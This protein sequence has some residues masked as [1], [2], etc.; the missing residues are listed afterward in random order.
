MRP[1]ME[2]EVANSRILVVDGDQ[3][4]RY[5]LSL[6]L[7]EKGLDVLTVTSV[8]KAV[9]I[10]D[11][12]PISVVILDQ[13]LPDTNGTNVCRMIRRNP[14]Y[15]AIPIV[16]LAED[17]SI[18]QR[19]RAY[20]NGAECFLVKPVSLRVLVASL[21]ALCRFRDRLLQ[22]RPVLQEE[23]RLQPAGL[24]DYDDRNSIPKLTVEHAIELGME[25]LRR[26]NTTAAIDWFRKAVE[27]DP[28]HVAARHYYK[29]AQAAFMRMINRKMGPLHNVPQH[30]MTDPNELA[31][32]EF[33][34][35]ESRIFYLIDGRSSFLEI[36]AHSPFTQEQ[37]LDLFRRLLA[38]KAIR[39][40]SRPNQ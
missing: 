25:S 34:S 24:P 13:E 16:L 12:Q 29:H 37:T 15:D 23:A 33:T 39:I 2:P 17:G 32:M 36:A 4:L 18:P 26:K 40:L 8:Q 21:D 1:G 20:K 35:Q 30:V 11:S 3:T 19:V 6:K 22:P 38:K 5:H 27:T 9:N 10:L 14:D 28:E 31:L 7:I